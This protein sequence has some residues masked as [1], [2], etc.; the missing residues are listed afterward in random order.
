MGFDFDLKHNPLGE[1]SPLYNKYFINGNVE[2]YGTVNKRSFYKRKEKINQSFIDFCQFRLIP[3]PKS[4]RKNNI[5]LE[6]C[7]RSISKYDKGEPFVN[8]KFW[9]FSLDCLEKMFRPH[10]CNSRVAS[11]ELAMSEL[12]KSSSPGWPATLKWMTKQEALEAGYESYLLEFWEKTS[13]VE[14]DDDNYLPIWTCS[15]KS[16]LR[17]VSKIEMFGGDYDKVRTF[18]AAPMEHTYLALR[19]YYD[20]NSKFYESNLKTWSFVGGSKY[21]RGWHRLWQFLSKIDTGWEL[22]ESDYDASIFAFLMEAVAD[23]RWSCLHHDD[24]TPENRKRHVFAYFHI[25][26]SLIVMDTG[27]FIRKFGGNPSGSQNTISDNTLALFVLIA[28]AFAK[29]YFDKFGKLPTYEILIKNV[30]AILNGDDNNIMV[31]REYQ[32]W[33]HVEAICEV[34]TSLMI[35]T[36]TPTTAPRKAEEMEFLSQGFVQI[37]EAPGVWL[38]LPNAEKVLSSLLYGST[39]QDVRWHMLRA[40]ALRLE[41]WT[42]VQCRLT[43]Q[44]YIDWMFENFNEQLTGTV[45]VVPNNPASVSLTWA[46]IFK[47]YKTD[48]E[49]LDLYI[50]REGNSSTSTHP[51]NNPILALEAKYNISIIN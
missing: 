9:N 38:P 4:H 10:L 7:V 36:K 28:Y 34:W 23:F 21:Y 8:Y 47:C 6:S 48:S 12:K 22:D 11:H 13:E 20:M 25:I 42:N 30:I 18:T 46:E 17:E 14:P 15:G 2:H 29:L 35:K 41:S 44:L 50:G 31:T 39:V 1:S 5:T 45:R 26:Y 37:P 19:L 24:Q 32:E 43:I 40:F 3:L 49:I 27:D 51:I 33:F 16:E